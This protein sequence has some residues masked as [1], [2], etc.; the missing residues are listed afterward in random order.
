MEVLE[1]DVSPIVEPSVSA[2]D[3]AAAALRG[4]YGP[5]EEEK[6]TMAEGLMTAVNNNKRKM[7]TFAAVAAAVVVCASVVAAIAY[8]RKKKNNDEGKQ[9]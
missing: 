2:R 8:R 1:E 7:M 3:I 5:I 4:D 9:K 6:P